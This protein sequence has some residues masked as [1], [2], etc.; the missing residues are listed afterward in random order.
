MDTVGSVASGLTGSFPLSALERVGRDGCLRLRFERRQDAT[1]L[2]RCAYTLPLQVLAPLRLPGP[3]AVVSML[4]P[5]GGIVGG[6]RLA[7]DVDVGS[8]AHAC[9]TTPAATKV[10]RTVGPE[11][12]QDVRLRVA[13]GGTLEW[14]PDHTIAFAGSAFRQTIEAQVERGGRLILLDAF[15]A[16][17]VARDEAWRFARLENIIT[18]REGSRWILHDR[19]L[20]DPEGPWTGVGCSDGCAYFGALVVIG[21][22]AATGLARAVTS[23]LT[24]DDVKGAAA[25]GPRGGL[26]ARV[27]AASAPAFMAALDTMW[28]LARRALLDLPPLALRKP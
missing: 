5:G 27:L 11:A 26:V 22:V 19:F 28:G 16:G 10:Y 2:T 25:P 1:V 7:V 20:L 9:L 14:V 23:A 15:A 17:R 6:D 18:V 3:A 13:A 4:N 8:G 12:R 21:E 24:R